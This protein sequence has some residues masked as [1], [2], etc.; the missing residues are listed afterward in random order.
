MIVTFQ[1]GGLDAYRHDVEIPRRYG[2]DQTVGDTL[3][4]GGVFRFLRSAPAYA[5]HRGATCANCVPDALL[6]N[7]ANPMAMNCWYPQPPGRQHGRAVPQRAGHVAHAGPPPR[8]ALRGGA[9][10]SGRRDQP[11]GVVPA[12][13]AQER[14]PLS[15]G[16]AR[17]MTRQHLPRAEQAG[18]GRGSTATTASR[19]A[20]RSTRA[21]TSACAP[22]SWPRSA[23]STP[24][25]ATTPRSTC[26]TS[27]R[28]QTLVNEFIAAALGLL[29]RSAPRTTNRADSRQLLAQ[30][31]ERACALASS[32]AR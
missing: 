19:A 20:H 15:R 5:G 27:A 3:G 9:A 23:T 17:T 8:R 14:R 4:P 30:A 24:S 32:M 1:V 11:P 7:Y 31:Q 2:V 13:P 21:A 26:P 10:T 6:I 25:R 29:T 12:V 28:I 22:R 18:A 16:C